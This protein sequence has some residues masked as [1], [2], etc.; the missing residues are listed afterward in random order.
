[1]IIAGQNTRRVAAILLNNQKGTMSTGVLTSNNTSLLIADQ[2]DGVVS[3][4]LKA[5]AMS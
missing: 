3:G 4:L 5:D 2:E 1:M